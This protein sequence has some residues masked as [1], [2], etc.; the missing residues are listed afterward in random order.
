MGPPGEKIPQILGH[1][2]GRLHDSLLP[3]NKNRGILEIENKVSGSKCPIGKGSI[4]REAKRYSPGELENLNFDLR[5]LGQVPTPEL[6]FFFS[7]EKCRDKVTA[8]IYPEG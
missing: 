4:I 5:Y 8:N 6:H 7:L 1:L 3:C 2:K